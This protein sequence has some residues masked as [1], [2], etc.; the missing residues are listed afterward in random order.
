MCYNIQE[1]GQELGFA[2]VPKLAGIDPFPKFRV[3]SPMFDW[4]SIIGFKDRAGAMIK[5]GRIDS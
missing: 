2:L 4:F 3:A 1:N 5:F